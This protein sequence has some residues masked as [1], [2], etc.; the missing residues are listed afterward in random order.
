MIYEHFSFIFAVP[1]N[2]PYK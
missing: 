2:T 1:A